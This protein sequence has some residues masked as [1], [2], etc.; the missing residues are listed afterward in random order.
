MFIKYGQSVSE[1]SPLRCL[2]AFALHI[3]KKTVEDF[4]DSEEFKDEQD[5]EDPGPNLI[6]QITNVENEF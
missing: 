3:F 1:H 6:I 5:T 4:E 2:R